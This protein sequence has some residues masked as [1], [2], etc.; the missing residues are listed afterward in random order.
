LEVI[1]KIAGRDAVV[2]ALLK[3]L[4]D[5]LYFDRLLAMLDELDTIGEN[6]R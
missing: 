2:G 1:D 6:N 4:A 3:K 5:G